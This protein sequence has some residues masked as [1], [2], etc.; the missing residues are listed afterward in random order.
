MP[1]GC[2]TTEQPMGVGTTNYFFVKSIDDV[3]CQSEAGL[4]DRFG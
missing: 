2:A 1:E 3:G 4:K